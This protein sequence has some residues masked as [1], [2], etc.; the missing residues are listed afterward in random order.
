M[1]PFHL[2]STLEERASSLHNLP[3][4]T[5]F[6]AFVDEMISVVDER[7]SLQNYRRIETISDLGTAISKSSGHSSLREV[8]INQIDPGGCAINMGDGLASLGVPVT[9]FASAGDPIH[10]AFAEYANKAELIS[11][12]VDPGRTLAFEFADGK[13]MFS[14]VSQL[15]KFHPDVLSDHLKDGRF[16]DACR[17][18]SLIAITDWTLY[19]HMT[20]CWEYLFETVFSELDHPRF[21][22]DLVDP[23]TRSDTDIRAMLGVL[24]R[25][26]RHGE[27]TLG[28]NQN[29]ANILSRLVDGKETSATDCESASNQAVHLRESLGLQSIIIHSVRYAVGAN[30]SGTSHA[31]GPYCK[32]PKKSTGAGD[33]FNAG[34]ALGL[35]LDLPLG[36]SLRVAVFCSGFFV[37]EGRSATFSELVQFIRDSEES[38]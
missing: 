34:Y 14:A 9:T 30:A 19:P 35:I 32:K 22:F 24:E 27:V 1:R 6:D 12:G 11:W 7:S 33:R 23:S 36:D 16:R 20:R 15:Q 2:A 18:A 31:L 37:R 13:L 25:Y 17:M 29:E 8:V 38:Q 26:R 5:G 21:F 28:L 4:V 10:P 3:V